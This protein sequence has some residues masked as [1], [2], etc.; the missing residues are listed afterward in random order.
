M[1]EEFSDQIKN[2]QKEK[3]KVLQYI[4]KQNER[5]EKARELLLSSVLD[6]KDYKMIKTEAE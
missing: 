6:V 3:K 5:L 1:I 4:Q 2:Q